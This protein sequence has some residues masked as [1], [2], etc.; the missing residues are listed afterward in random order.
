MSDSQAKNALTWAI[1]S[2]RKLLL[3]WRGL[4]N[5]VFT[6][7]AVALVINIG[8]AGIIGSPARKKDEDTE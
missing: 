1:N 8:F 4:T 2:D 5:A 7:F 3:S 6:L